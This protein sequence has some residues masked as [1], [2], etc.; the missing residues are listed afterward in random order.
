M[1]PPKFMSLGNLM[2][3]LNITMRDSD[4]PH[5]LRALDDRSPDTMISR[6]PDTLTTGRSAQDD[7]QSRSELMDR[8]LHTLAKRSS[9]SGTI[10]AGVVV[11]VVAFLLICGG[12]YGW[13]R[14]RERRRTGPPKE[15]MEE[16]GGVEEDMDD[17][18]HY[19]A[20]IQNAADNGVRG[21]KLYGPSGHRNTMIL[22]GPVVFD[23]QRGSVFGGQR[24]SVFGGQRGSVFGGQSGRGSR[25]SREHHR[26]ASGDSQR[27]RVSYDQ[28]PRG[29]H[30]YRPRAS[31]DHRRTASDD[32]GATVFGE[33]A[34]MVAPSPAHT[35]LRQGFT[36]ER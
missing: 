12:V 24:G 25:G 9:N 31:N 23:G 5:N 15:M 35:P 29:S 13:W 36:A 16:R 30:D 33:P 19:D 4:A 26:M 6:F 7:A 11:G 3:A 21:S 20:D 32:Q 18:D 17:G 22:D 2:S 1:S 14:M 34:V 27:T 28:R 8:T 10:I